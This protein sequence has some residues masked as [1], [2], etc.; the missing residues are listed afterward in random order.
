MPNLPDKIKICLEACGNSQCGTALSTYLSAKEDL[1]NFEVLLEEYIA[2][3]DM[4]KQEFSNIK[5]IVSENP[6]YFEDAETIISNFEEKESSTEK[7]MSNMI[8]FVDFLIGLVEDED[9]IEILNNLNAELIDIR[10][11]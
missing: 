6:E 7:D 5:Q 2:A 8:I 3:S 9:H 11:R 1:E 4:I 10:D